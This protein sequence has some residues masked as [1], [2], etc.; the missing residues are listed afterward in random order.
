MTVETLNITS[1]PYIGNNLNDT[2][3]Y[4][5]TVA[6]KT[7]LSVYETTDSGARTLLVVDTDY[8]VN[9]VGVDGG[10][11][12]VRTAGN[13]PTDYLW[14]IR[15]NRAENQLTD[16]SSQGAFFPDIHEDQM[17][18]ITFLIQQLR[19]T[20]GH[21]FALSDTIA[22]DG[23]LTISEDAD[24]RADLSLGFDS[25]GNLVVKTL[26][27]P[28]LIDQAELDKRHTVT[29]SSV[30]A[31]TAV[32]PLDIAGNAVTLNVGL[33]V[34]TQGYYTAG[35][36]G[37]AEY[38]IVAPQAF[39]G[40]GDHELNNNNI[41]VLQGFDI[42]YA[43]QYGAKGDGS[44]DDLPS[45]QAALTKL[46]TAG[47]GVLTLNLPDVGYK[48]DGKIVLYDRIKLTGSVPSEFTVGGLNPGAVVLLPTSTD[49]VGIECTTKSN[50]HLEN[51]AIDCTNVGATFTGVLWDGVQQ[52][53]MKNV[54][55]VEM[56]LAGHTG[57][58]FNTDSRGCY[59]NN[60]ENVKTRAFPSDLGKGFY[61]KGKIGERVNQIVLLNCNAFDVYDGFVLDYV[62]SGIT[63]IN[64]TGESCGNDGL[65]ITNT[66]YS[67]APVCIGGEFSN[68]A[69][70]GAN[71]LVHLTNTA[72]SGNAS[73]PTTNGAFR[74]FIDDTNGNFLHQQ[75]GVHAWDT[76]VRVLDKTITA[77]SQEINSLLYG[78]VS[79]EGDT[80]YTLTSTPS[81]EH[82][83]R[84]GQLITITSMFPG[85]NTITL[86][87]DAT[88]ANSDL[89][90]KGGGTITLTSLTS[91]TF[92]WRTADSKWY[93][94]GRN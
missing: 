50:V 3:S 73:G 5:F 15:S 53:T 22:V 24:A 2:Y 30:S 8:T 60:L 58:E 81:I 23:T 37:G 28:S 91:I 19:D 41:A 25:A 92:R 49:T 35:D 76:S 65:L 11:T 10:G 89:F 84:D 71:G 56:S 55:V 38:L 36:G 18:H 74:Q 48:I 39:D 82:G 51:I 85:A 80:A 64:C 52:S 12:I 4:D 13:L 54:S 33:T 1:G 78:I 17:D 14:Y 86:Q 66:T 6:D 27:D 61:F 7:Q 63:L 93:E 40:Y 47:A 21:Q 72:L 88:L 87:D 32:T 69:G 75:Y 83:E 20:L 57:F 70:Y 29:F 34:F 31:M 9:N 67:G 46:N 90:L 45:I 68:N 62:G 79:V 59:W 94:V 26:F 42:L 77:A 44:T 43:F 16:F